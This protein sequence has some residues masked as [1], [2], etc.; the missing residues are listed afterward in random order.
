MYFVCNSIAYN[1]FRLGD[2]GEF[3]ALQLELLLKL[4]RI[5]EAEI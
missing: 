4:I 2:G 5:T 1:G 3:D